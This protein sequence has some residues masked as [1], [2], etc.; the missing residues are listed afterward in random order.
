MGHLIEL[1]A[2]SGRSTPIETEAAFAEA[3]RWFDQA[4]R[5][6]PD[7]IAVDFAT[8]AAAYADYT[9]YLE[10]VGYDLD[11]VFSTPA[12]TDLAVAKSHTLTPAIVEHA[13]ER[14]GLSLGDESRLPPTT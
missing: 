5:N 3:A 14:C 8:Y 9:R 1:L 2:P 7:D 11:A 13:T 10:S 12:G 6:A 4:N